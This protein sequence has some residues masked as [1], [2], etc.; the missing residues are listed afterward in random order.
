MTTSTTITSPPTTSPS[1]DSADPYARIAEL[2][3]ATVAALADRLEIRASDPRQHELWDAFLSRLPDVAGRVLDV[4]CGTGTITQKIALLPAVSEAV[5]IDPCPGFVERARRRAP[6]LRFEVA[7]GRAL[8][9]PD[10]AFD[11]VVLA[12]TLCHVPDP[13]RALAEA[14]RVLRRGGFL[15]VYEGDYAAATVALARHD[16]LQACVDAAVAALVH[17]PWLVRRLAPLVRRTGFATEGLVDHGYLDADSPTYSPSLIDAGADRLAA[18]GTIT[19]STAAALKDE[20]RDRAAADR[21]FG[22]VGYVSLLAR[23]R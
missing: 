22:H 23:R 6:R 18:A 17:D 11:G 16:P 12:T 20:A 10:H 8:P 5:G 3:D 15:L 14:H 13:G 7:D 21:Y 9:F 2:D 4:G 1:A 19:A